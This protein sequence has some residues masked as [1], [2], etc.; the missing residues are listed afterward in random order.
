MIG[1]FRESLKPAFYHRSWKATRLKF[2]VDLATAFLPVRT[3]PTTPR[4]CPGPCLVLRRLT[5][6]LM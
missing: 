6:S 5:M 4:L 3:M 2:Q 1:S